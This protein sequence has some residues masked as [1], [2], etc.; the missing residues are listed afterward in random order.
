M[1]QKVDLTSRKFGKIQVLC[2]SRKR[3]SN[4]SIYWECICDCGR[5][6][7]IRQDALLSGATTSCYKCSVNKFYE[8]NDYMVCETTKGEKILF[9]VDSYDN[10]KEY[11]WFLS[12][13]YATTNINGRQVKMHRLIMNAKRNQLID[14]INR[15]PTDNRMSNL[16]IATD[17]QNGMNKV[18]QSG[19]FTSKYKG[20]YWRKDRQVWYARIKKDKKTIFLG[21]YQSEKDAANAYNEKAIEL[22]GEY[23]VLNKIH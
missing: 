19:N 13:G 7:L 11:S 15:I 6:K 1:G 8:E 12:L 16:R 2:E 5:E 20:V 22:F 10:I 9:D 14:H 23:C 21:S 3:G 4:G 17:S 18:K